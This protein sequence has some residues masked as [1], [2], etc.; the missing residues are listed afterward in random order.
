MLQ[1]P[2]LITRGLGTPNQVTRGYGF[3]GQVVQ[4]VVDAGRRVVRGGRSALKKAE[5]YLYRVAVAAR[6]MSKAEVMGYRSKTEAFD[7]GFPQVEGATYLEIDPSKRILVRAK[8]LQS[9]EKPEEPVI[10][11]GK[12]IY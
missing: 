8:P 12:R 4:A 10:V 6:L 11:T 1:G 5:E 9:Q 7:H 3:F 2:G